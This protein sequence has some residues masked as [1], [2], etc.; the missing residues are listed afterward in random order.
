MLHQQQNLGRKM[1]KRPTQ[2]GLKTKASG[3]EAVGSQGT[4]VGLLTV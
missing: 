3:A 4:A 2:P 1:L